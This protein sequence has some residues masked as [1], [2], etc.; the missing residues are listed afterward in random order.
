MNNA[1]GSVKK[2]FN[3]IDVI[4]ILLAIAVAFF[5]L[6]IIFADFF[7]KES[8]PVNFI[9]RINETDSTNVSLLNKGDFLYST[10]G[11]FIGKIEDISSVQSTVSA[12]NYETSR[13]TKAVLPDRVDVY[14]T[15]STECT[16]KNNRL[17]SGS[18]VISENTIITPTLT[19]SFKNA[20]IISVSVI[21]ST[22]ENL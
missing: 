22:E 17:Y 11:S 3:I 2:H 13:F 10:N 8:A 4:I 5:A 1:N 18:S 7:S 20:E 14:I 21:S 15:L 6:N 19:F 9:I 12:F 16:I